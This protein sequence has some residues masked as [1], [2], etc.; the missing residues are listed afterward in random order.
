M[1]GEIRNADLLLSL[2]GLSPLLEGWKLRGSGRL[3]RRLSRRNSVN[4]L[5]NEFISRLP[6]KVRSGV[7]P[8]SSSLFDLSRTMG[9]TKGEKEYYDKQ[10]ATLKSFEEVDSFVASDSVYEEDLEEQAQHERAMKISNYAN[11]LLLAFK[12]FATVKS[13]SLAIAASTL[14]SLLDLMAGGI[15]WFTHLSMKNIDIYKY[16]IGK[17]RV[18][19]VGIVVFAAIMATLGF[20]VLVQAIEQL[21]ENKPPAKMTTEQLVWLYAIM[22]TATVVK[23]VLWNYCRSSGNKIVRAYAKDHYFDVVTNVVGLVA[24]VLGDKFFWWL[25]PAGALI[26]A[27]YT[28][29]NWSGTVLENAVS[30]VGQSAPPEVLQKLTYL[31]IRHPQVRRVD[32]VRAY[33]FGVLYFVEVDIELPIDLPLNEAHTIGETL[34]IKIEKLPEV[35][36][37]FVHLDFECEHKPE[38]SILSRLPN[39]EP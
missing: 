27:I 7:D 3:S 9:L 1:E 6:D 12:I 37:A 4:S 13:G 24:A 11:I 39:S 25:D 17:L 33:T 20:Q 16:P 31:V 36:R 21:V 5:R 22:I 18:Q 8:E 29:S 38:H 23:L 2:L 10:F 35:E 30:L 34:Q 28:I 26:L 15:L 19:P 14:D 32:T